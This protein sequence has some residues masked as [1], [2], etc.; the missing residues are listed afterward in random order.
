MK[1]VNWLDFS[2]RLRDAGVDWG[3]FTVLEVE[4]DSNLVR[5]SYS[6]DEAS[7]PSGGQ[8]SLMASDWAKHVIFER[9]PWLSTDLKSLRW[10]FTDADLLESMGLH[11]ALNVPIV[12]GGR[13]VR[14][15]NLLRAA[16]P[17][18]RD[19]LNRLSVLLTSL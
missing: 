5:R 19:E 8:K 12:N 1:S 15:L 16:E 6:S 17:Y 13:T 7:Y 14:T 9:S 4:W 3:L 18:S 11:F 2:G 10:A